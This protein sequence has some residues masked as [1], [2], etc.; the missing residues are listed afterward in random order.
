MA[1]KATQAIN[2]VKFKRNCMESSEQ[3][4]ASI[5]KTICPKMLLFGK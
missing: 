1:G 2:L 4:E 5:S 3:N